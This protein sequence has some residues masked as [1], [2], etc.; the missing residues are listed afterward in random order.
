MLIELL[1]MLH[2]RSV[3]SELSGS[4]ILKRR[5]DSI[6][7]DTNVEKFLSPPLGYTKLYNEGAE[8]FL[9]RTN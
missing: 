1:A 4:T 3:E 7:E 2:R 5:S 8:L 9:F 6:V